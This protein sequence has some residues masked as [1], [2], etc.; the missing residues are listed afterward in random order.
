[1]GE[2]FAAHDP[3]LD[4]EV[5]VTVVRG[6]RADADADRTLREEARKL[7]ELSHPN[8]VQVY[9]VA[10]IGPSVCIAMELVDGGSLSR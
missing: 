9:D 1:M 3:T 10:E 6:D 2:V 5:A 8:I 7:A 4:R